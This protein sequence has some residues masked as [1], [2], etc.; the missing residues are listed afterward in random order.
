LIIWRAAVV[1]TP[2][3]GAVETAGTVIAANGDDLL[4]QC[5]DQ[6]ALRLLE[7]QPESKRRMSVRDFLNGTHLKVGDRFGEA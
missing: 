5:G 3:S 6:T 4:V 2:A 1:E 7:V